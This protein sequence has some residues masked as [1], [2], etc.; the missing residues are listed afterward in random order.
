MMYIDELQYWNSST[1]LWAFLQFV[2]TFYNPLILGVFPL[3]SHG[4]RVCLMLKQSLLFPDLDNP[5]IP[6]SLDVSI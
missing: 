3:V 6:T 4:L 5:Q 2:G 1:D